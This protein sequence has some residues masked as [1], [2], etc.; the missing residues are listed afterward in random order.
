[1]LLEIKNLKKVYKGKV[2][3]NDDISHICSRG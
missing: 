3:A 2:K 1:M